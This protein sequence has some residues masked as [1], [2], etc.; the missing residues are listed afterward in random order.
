MYN[1]VFLMI[2]HDSESHCQLSLSVTFLLLDGLIIL[3]YTLPPW[4]YTNFGIQ[5]FLFNH[6]HQFYML[7]SSSPPTDQQMNRVNFLTSVFPHK[8]QVVVF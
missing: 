6:S 1:V 2:L 4:E 7:A 5:H 8:R 3:N